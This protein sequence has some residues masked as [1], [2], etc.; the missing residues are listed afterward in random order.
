[1]TCDII[2][3]EGLQRRRF[4]RVNWTNLM[5]QVPSG[6]AALAFLKSPNGGR[7]LVL[8]RTYGMVV[9]A[10][11]TE[12]F[13][14]A[15]DQRYTLMRMPLDNVKEFLEPYVDDLVA[16]ELN[17]QYDELQLYVSENNLP[18]LGPL[19]SARAAYAMKHKSMSPEQAIAEAENQATFLV[20]MQMNRLKKIE[21]MMNADGKTPNVFT[22]VH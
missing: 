13:E 17:E 19:S 7:T 9:A 5:T 2:S 16:P 15:T 18:L 14:G 3:I 11:L 8:T 12:N 21:G 10:L 22:A 4:K 20:T 6:T 1:M